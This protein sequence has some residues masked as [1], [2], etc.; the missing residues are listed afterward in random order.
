MSNQKKEL[1]KYT[2]VWGDTVVLKE[3]LLACLIG[4][5]VTMTFFFIGQN[6]FHNIEGLDE[7]M[8]NGYALLLGLGGCLISG[9]VNARLFKPKRTFDGRLESD[10]IESILEQAGMTVEEEAAALA[11]VEPEIIAEL[12]DLEMY[13]LLALVPEDS[14]NYK[15][16][17]KEKAQ[18]QINGQERE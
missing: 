7:G 18:Q 2:E 3:L 12:E 6:V 15:V 13:S 11:V 8:A 9:V 17:Y 16:E 5:V 10:S 1:P 14:P 4:M